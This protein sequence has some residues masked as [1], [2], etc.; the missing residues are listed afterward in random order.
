MIRSVSFLLLAALVVAPSASPAA[1]SDTIKIGTP[2]H[3]AGFSWSLTAISWV[4]K[5]NAKAAKVLSEPGCHADGDHGL[6]A[7]PFSVK[8]EQV[9]EGAGGMALFVTYKD[10]SSASFFVNMG[11]SGGADTYWV[12]DAPK[13]SKSNP[14]VSVKFGNGFNDAGYP[15]FFYL[16]NPTVQ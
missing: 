7:F 15:K 14:I 3:Y 6:L 13:P 5:S 12:C 4:A 2:F 11:G 8:S 16:N 9:G 1:P 10:G